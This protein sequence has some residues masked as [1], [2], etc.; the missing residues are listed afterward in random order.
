MGVFD[1]QIRSVE[2]LVKKYGQPVTIV[3]SVSDTPDPN[4]PWEQIED[5][6]IS[7]DVYMVFLSPSVSGSA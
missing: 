3:S 4:K 2:R 6:P 5:I 1:R 7:T